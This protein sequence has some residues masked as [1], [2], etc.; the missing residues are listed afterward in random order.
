LF[1]LGYAFSILLLSL[2]NNHASP[3]PHFQAMT[4]L[5]Y[6]PLFCGT[7]VVLMGMSIPLADYA[8]WKYVEERQRLT[9]TEREGEH[10]PLWERA[11]W[12]MPMRY[13]GGVVGFA[14]AAS[15]LNWTSQVQLYAVIAFAALALWFLFDRTGLGMVVSLAV[16]IGSW[17]G[18]MLIITPGIS[19]PVVDATGWMP[20]AIFSANVAF[21]NIGRKLFEREG[22][23]VRRR[24]SSLGRPRS[25]H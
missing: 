16:G 17:L 21:G 11:E 9:R 19:H 18:F 22:H 25:N 2:E 6:F 12:S 7:T 4:E 8:Y 14:W 15:R 3:L 24:Y 1:A 20:S 13:I 5:K 23:V 10:R